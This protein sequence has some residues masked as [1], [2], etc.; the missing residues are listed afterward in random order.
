[1]N[2]IQE[3]LKEIRQRNKMTQKAFAKLFYVTEKTISNYEHGRRMPD[4]EFLIKICQ[5]FNIPLDYFA[6]DEKLES[7]YEN[8]TQVEKNNKTGLFDVRQSKFLVPPIYDRI[9]KSKYG[10]HIVA[11]L[12]KP[13]DVQDYFKY[14]ENNGLIDNTLFSPIENIKSTDVIDNDGNL[15]EFPNL[16]LGLCH[17]FDRHNKCI[18]YNKHDHLYYLVNENGKKRS[19]G[20]DEIDIVAPYFQERLYYAVKDNKHCI[21]DKDG[22]VLPIK[23]QR[24]GFAKYTLQQKLSDEEIYQY[25]KN[26]GASMILLLLGNSRDNRAV[27]PIIINAMLEFIDDENETDLK[28]IL[29]HFFPT[30]VANIE[31]PVFTNKPVVNIKNKIIRHLITNEINTLYAKFNIIVKE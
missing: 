26:Y 11:T 2:K 6:E 30:D 16:I 15:K 7:K 21:L 10:Y 13:I 8:L 28:W 20:Y 19:E 4:I 18:A 12:K 25:I 22:Q 23:I 3:K 5:K 9:L 31:F 27:Y 14:T 17:E 1:M 24:N 29:D